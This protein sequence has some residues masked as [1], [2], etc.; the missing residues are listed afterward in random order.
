MRRPWKKASMCA[1][2]R[3]ST[4]NGRVGAERIHYQV[5][6]I[7]ISTVFTSKHSTETHHF[8]SY[9]LFIVTIVVPLPYPF[10][11]VIVDVPLYVVL[12]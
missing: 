8:P 12:Y 5:C 4:A 1:G 2:A 9:N 7:Q 6:V 10:P 3:T 11:I